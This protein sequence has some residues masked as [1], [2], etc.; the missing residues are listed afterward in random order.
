MSTL[1]PQLMYPTFLVET[2]DPLAMVIARRTR[3]I[4]FELT[5]VGTFPRTNESSYRVHV[6]CKSVNLHHLY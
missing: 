4:P 5:R 2:K 1:G 3:F 6:E